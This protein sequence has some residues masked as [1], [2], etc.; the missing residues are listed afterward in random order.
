M[1]IR[2]TARSVRVLLPA[3]LLLAACGGEP[4]PERLLEKSAGVPELHAFGSRYIPLWRTAMAD[5]DATALIAE[6]RELAR[7][8]QL[9]AGLDVPASIR[10]QRSE[11]ET[12]QRLFS[13]AVDYLLVVLGESHDGVPDPQAFHQA[14]QA[15]YDWWYLLVDLL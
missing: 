14:V 2:R 11:W 12:N 1:R 8:K 5:S 3:I 7:I 6:A 4:S 15:V 9:I 10:L 13:R